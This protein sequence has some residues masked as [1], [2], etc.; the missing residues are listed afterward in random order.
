MVL[1]YRAAV[2]T[3]GR[4][5]FTQRRGRC[6][7]ISAGTTRVHSLPEC[8][9]E[10]C[11][12]WSHGQVPRSRP[13]LEPALC[14]GALGGAGPSSALLRSGAMGGASL[15]TFRGNGRGCNASACILPLSS[16]PFFSR[17]HVG[18]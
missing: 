11:R 7:V 17:C 3:T 13:E 15:G 16:A 1:I 5:V 12:A 10:P 2:G 4:C 14:A 9:R 8:L 18:H 6:A